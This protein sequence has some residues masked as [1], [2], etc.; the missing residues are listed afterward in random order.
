MR[1]GNS[2][3]LYKSENRCDLWLQYL[4]FLSHW[5]RH[6]SSWS[7]PSCR[8]TMETEPPGLQMMGWKMKLLIYLIIRIVCSFHRC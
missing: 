2:V 3:K 7:L 8:P 4:L 5:T 6:C 1:G